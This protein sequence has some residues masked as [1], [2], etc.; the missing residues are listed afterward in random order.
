MDEVR[1]Q[2]R[3]D[4]LVKIRVEALLRGDTKTAQ[5]LALELDRT[6]GVTLTVSHSSPCCTYDNPRLPMFPHLV[7]Q[8]HCP[9]ETKAFRQSSNSLD[10]E[11]EHMLDRVQ[12]LVR[13]RS[14][15]RDDCKFLEADAIRNELWYTYVSLQPFHRPTV[16]E[17][18]RPSNDT[19]RWCE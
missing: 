12:F 1:V 5:Y 16:P 19:E 10:L 11:H 14:E 6:Y 18:T 3:V 4:Q 2:Q 15:K 9:G 13:E 17:L 8:E 7:Y